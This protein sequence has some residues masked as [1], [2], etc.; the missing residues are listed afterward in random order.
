LR[1]KVIAGNWKMNGSAMSIRALLDGL[2]GRFVDRNAEVVLFPPAPYLSMVVERATQLRVSVGAQSA[3]SEPRGAYT[4]EIS[5]EMAR[6]LG[7]TYLLVGHSERRQRFGETDTVV[8][9]KFGA[10][11][12]AGL[13]P[14]LCVGETAAERDAGR[15]EDVV[16]TQLSAIVT[17]HGVEGLAGAVIAYEPVWAIGTGR[18]AT[19]FDAEGMHAALRVALAQSSERVATEQRILYGGSV[20]AD[21][22]RALLGARGVDGVLVGGAS[23]D[24]V[25]FAAIFEAA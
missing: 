6:D 21:N 7:A 22:A 19:P 18:T 3:H 13:I 4:G 25:Q 8:A 16:R 15:A 14:M 17:A 23:L 24:P 20:T 11:R 2:E 10:A 5:A 12:R 1:R 9:A